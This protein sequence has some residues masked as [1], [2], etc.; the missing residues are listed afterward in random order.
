MRTFPGVWVP[1]GGHIELGEGLTEA[2]L[3]ELYEEVGIRITES[4]LTSERVLCMWESVYPYSLSMGQPKRHHLVIY[5]KVVTRASREELNNELKLDAEE[6]DA[7]MWMGKE[8]AKVVATGHLDENSPTRLDVICFGENGIQKK[9]QIAAKVMTNQAPS[10]GEDIERI[11][12]GTRFAL[13]QW[14]ANLNSE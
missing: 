13:E 14:L 11:S 6:V 9:S 5:I 4:D 2:A 1:P 10:S 12:T 3:R 8:A 7:A